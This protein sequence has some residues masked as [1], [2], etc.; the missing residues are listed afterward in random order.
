MNFLLDILLT[1]HLGK[2]GTL[3]G[4]LFY[5]KIVKVVASRVDP[6]IITL[7]SEEEIRANLGTDG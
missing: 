6:G 5:R 7:T 4:S 3:F 1:G 2:P